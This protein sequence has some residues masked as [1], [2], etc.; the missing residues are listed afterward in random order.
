[1]ESDRRAVLPAPEPSPEAAPYWDLAAKGVLGLQFCTRCARHQFPPRVVCSSCWR[2]DG[3]EWRHAAGTGTIYSYSVVHRPPPGFE[4]EV[5]YVVAFI[6]L[7]E[8]PRILTNLT[9]WRQGEPIEIGA[10]VEVEFERR[11]DMALPQFNVVR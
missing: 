3:L 9:R 5:P 2:D 11:G 10:R 8:G 1:M 4:D 6:E 7:D